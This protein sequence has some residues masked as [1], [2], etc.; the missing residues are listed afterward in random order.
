MSRDTKNAYIDYFN[1][2]MTPS[3]ARSFHEMKI[4]SLHDK[5]VVVHLAD[6]QINPREREIIYLYNEWR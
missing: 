5:D 6:S 3:T 2:V 4:M 1:D